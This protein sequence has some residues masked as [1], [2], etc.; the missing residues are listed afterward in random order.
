M[1][2][3]PGSVPRSCPRLRRPRGSFV[4]NEVPP[5]AFG[6]SRK[7]PPPGQGPGRNSRKLP[8]GWRSLDVVSAGGGPGGGLWLEL[9]GRGPRGRRGGGE[10]GGGG[11][12]RRGGAPGGPPPAAG[13]GRRA[14]PP[15]GRAGGGGGARDPRG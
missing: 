13:R 6:G 10:G 2:N 12:G 5:A 9:P 8:H 4:E 1:P 3:P 15:P 11:G 7:R 14:G